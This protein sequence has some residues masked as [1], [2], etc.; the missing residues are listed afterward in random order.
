MNKVKKVERCC[1]CVDLEKGVKMLG[2][3][4]ALHS[5]MAIFDFHIGRT[6]VFALF[7]IAF[8]VML[9]KNV[10]V[11]RLIFLFAYIFMFVLIQ[12]INFS[13]ASYDQGGV[14]IHEQA[15]SIC[16]QMGATMIKEFEESHGDCIPAM[17]N[18]VYYFTAVVLIFS[19]VLWLYFC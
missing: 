18:H 3:I 8:C 4:T 10:A 2:A 1:F 12:L 13:W 19:T 14:D 16:N 7:I 17:V 11:T 9:F 6:I 5:T 15:V